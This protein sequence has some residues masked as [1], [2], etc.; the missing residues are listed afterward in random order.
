MPSLTNP[1]VL[2]AAAIMTVVAVFM[3]VRT[4]HRLKHGKTPTEFAPLPVA[5]PTPHS[6]EGHRSLD[7]DGDAALAK[8]A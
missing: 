1:W 3:I 6:G 4:M 7:D 8:G 5:L 2:T